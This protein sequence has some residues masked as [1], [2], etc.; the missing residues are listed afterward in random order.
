MAVA[1]FKIDEA[2]QTANVSP[3]MKFDINGD[4]CALIKI[5]TTQQHF[6]F[7][8]GSLGVSH[9]EWQN[10]DH[11]GEIWLYVPNGVMKISI[12]HPQLGS[13]K[14]F[15]MGQRLKKGRT[16][17]MELTSDRI[18]TLVVDYD[19][20]QEVE[21]RVFPPNANFYINGIRQPLSSEG[22]ATLQLPYGTHN[23]RVVATNYHPIESRITIKGHDDTKTLSVR[24]KQAFGYLNVKGGAEYSGAEV[25]IDNVLVDT[26]PMN[27]YHLPSGGHDISI[28]PQYYKPYSEHVNMTD[29][30]TVNISATFSPNFAEYEII[31]PDASTEIYDNGTL[32][33]SGHWKGRL[34]AGVHTLEAHKTNHSPA[35]QRV[36]VANGID[37]KVTLPS[38]S[39]IYGGIEITSTPSRAKVFIDDKEVGTTPYSNSSLLI[40]Q[41]HINLSLTGHKSEEFDIEIKEGKSENVAKTLTDVC[42]FI[43][44]SNPVATLTIEDKNL[45]T[46][47][48][49]FTGS[50]GD[51]ALKLTAQGYVEWNKTI[52]IDG[53]TPDFTIKLKPNYIHRNEIY[54]SFGYDFGGVIG[55]FLGIGGYLHNINLEAS[56]TLGK[57]GTHESDPI[58]WA[59]PN[60]QAPPKEATY[61]PSIAAVKIGY[62]FILTNRMRLTPQLGCHYL[63]LGENGDSVANGANAM[64]LSLGARYNIAFVRHFGISMSSEYRLDI[65]KSPG[66]AAISGVSSKIKGYAN[67]FSCNVSF[68]LFF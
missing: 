3:T 37:N 21:V 16:Y 30:A 32:L 35:V 41:H 50:G 8:V 55:P 51:Y 52:H 11:P 59:D 40:G 2:D 43:L 24:L 27:G 33:A 19:N 18:N 58:F 10:S 53:S 45:G 48:Y 61:T 39:P 36:I 20:S 54:L 7:D 46:T 34:V 67:G 5:S 12:Q 44:S 14:D 29:S 4:K 65:S 23:Y 31:A 22:H 28:R 56:T 25:Y 42:N 9:T 68:N 47:P 6:S 66:F 15:D 49:H 13:I 17:V 63:W 60:M 64:S 38:P 57:Y 26:L 62:G 1:S